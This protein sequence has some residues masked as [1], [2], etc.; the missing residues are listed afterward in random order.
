MNKVSKIPTEVMNT[1]KLDILRKYSIIFKNINLD[2]ISISPILMARLDLMKTIEMIYEAQLDKILKTKTR[3]SIYLSEV[4]FDYMKK[5]YKTSRTFLIQNLANLVY[6]AEKYNQYPEIGMFLMFLVSERENLTFL[7]YIYLRQHYKIISNTNFIKHHKSKVNPIRLQT[8][9][10]VCL[11]ILEQ[12][13]YYDDLTKRKIIQH[14]KKTF[15]GKGQISFYKFMTGMTSL[16]LVY[17]DLRLMENLIAVYSI[18]NKRDLIQVRFSEFASRYS[19]Y[20]DFVNQGGDG[21]SRVGSNR[22]GGTGSKTGKGSNRTGSNR[23]GRKKVRVNEANNEVHIDGPMN[24][25]EFD[26]QEIKQ[27]PKQMSRFQVQSAPQ[28]IIG[29][30]L[31]RKDFVDLEPRELYTSMIK[32][33]NFKLTKKD[34]GIQDIILN[35]LENHTNKILKSF[36]KRNDVVHS[37]LTQMIAYAKNKVHKKLLFICVSIFVNSRELFFQLLRKELGK[38]DV[39]L[40]FWDKLSG[41]YDQLKETGKV[42]RSI[43]KSFLH[44]LFADNVL[45]QQ[46]LFFLNFHFKTDYEIVNYHVDFEFTKDELAEEVI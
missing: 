18:K 20:A 30:P 28:E 32:K 17:K 35:E 1:S 33:K 25:E 6:S 13:F 31:D 43:A 2:N 21:G 24:D 14:F 4:A 9:Q 36:I 41:S 44:A 15:A 40:T 46:V 22:L 34:K 23:S 19:D 26:E 10:K 3:Y 39:I 16:K 8:S 5:R 12:A 11:M 29:N 42:D 38:D 7:F 27:A 45:S 37:D